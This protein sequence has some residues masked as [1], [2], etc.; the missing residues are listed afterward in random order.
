M[1]LVNSLPGG[2]FPLVYKHKL[3]YS[4]A[5]RCCAFIEENFPTKG[6]T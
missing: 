6:V 4:D 1:T 3:T 2:C 5:V